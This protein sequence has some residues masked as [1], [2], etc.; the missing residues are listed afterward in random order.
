MQ[1][2][3]KIV[4]ALVS[5]VAIAIG[6]GFLLNDDLRT[7]QV[8][9]EGLDYHML[10]KP[11]DT[12]VTGKIEVREAFSY[13]C[14][15]C[16][17]FEPMIKTWGRRQSSD[18]QLVKQ[19]IVWSIEIEHYAR[20][21]HIGIALGIADKAD[22]AIFTAVHTQNNKLETEDKA[23]ALFATLG[24][25]LDA[26]HEIYQSDKIKQQAKQSELKTLHLGVRSIPQMVVAGRYVV[27]VNRETGFE[28]MLKVV[29]F[30]VEKIRD[31]DF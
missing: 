27:L 28:G 29:D 21:Q 1:P 8:Y 10:P 11:L 15:H 18:V 25:S 7:P 30:L 13:T 2:S 4:A 24:V 19:Q 20:L 26:F 22:A 16:Y 5:L 14:G 31:E 17:Q 23:A 6:L 12:D 9:V 3:I